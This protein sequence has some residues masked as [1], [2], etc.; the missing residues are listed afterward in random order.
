MLIYHLLLEI[1]S[2][3]ISNL[4]LF[5][6]ILSAKCQ[7]HFPKI[8]TH[9]RKNSNLNSTVNYCLVHVILFQDYKGT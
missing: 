8:N 6:E 1:H 5:K 4:L 7:N 2:V 9:T 3:T